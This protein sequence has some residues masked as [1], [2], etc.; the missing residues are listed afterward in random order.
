MV[1]DIT[2]LISSNFFTMEVAAVEAADLNELNI[3]F[4]RLP[5]KLAGLKLQQTSWNSL[6]SLVIGVLVG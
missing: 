4:V 1:E 5:V 6:P 3:S 2:S